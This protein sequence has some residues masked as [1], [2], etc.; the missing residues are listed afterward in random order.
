ALQSLG[1]DAVSM[2]VDFYTYLNKLYF[3][4]DYD[5]AFLGSTFEN[6]DVDWLAY[7]F[8]SEYSD[9]PYW[10]FPNFRNSSYDSWRNQLLHSADY[11]DVY[12]A[13]IE[14]Q[15]IL[16]YECPYI[17]A[18]ENLLLSAYRN[19]R[20]EGHV[21]DFA[22][23]AAGWW[24]NH[25]VHLKDALG[26]PYGG[27]FRWAIPL[28]RESFNLLNTQSAYEMSLKDE[29]YDR[30]LKRTPDGEIIPWLAE[31]YIAENHWDNPEVPEG[32]TRLTFEFVR[33]ASWSDGMP[34]TAQDAAF[35][36]N[37]YYEHGLVGGDFLQEDLYAAYAPTDYKLVVEFTGES[38]WYITS[39][40]ELSVLPKHQLAG[41][42]PYTWSPSWDEIITSG[43]FVLVERVPG[44]LIRMEKNPRYFR[45]PLNE[46]TGE[47][48][49]TA[50]L[51][52]NPPSTEPFQDGLS[53]ELEMHCPVGEKYDQ[54]L[55]DY[56]ETEELPDTV[57]KTAGG[58]TN[59]I[60]YVSS[61]QVADRLQ[62]SLDIKWKMDLGPAVVL[63][64]SIASARD[65][66]TLGDRRGVLF[67]KADVIEKRDNSMDGC[68]PREPN[69]L[70]IRDLI[71][72]TGTSASGYTGAGVTVGVVDSGTDF[73]HPDLQG[74]ISTDQYGRPTSYDPTGWGIQLM[75]RANSSILADPEAWL[76]EGNVLTYEQDGRYYLNI[77]GWDP[78][79]NNQGG[80]RHLM[81]LLPPYGDGYPEGD[82]F[83]FI[84]AY[85]Y[86][87]GIP[88]FSEFVFNEM[89]KDWEI[90][91]PS[92][93]DYRIGWVHEQRQDRYAKVFAP[94]LIIDGQQLVIDWNGS[95]AWTQMWNWA[96]HDRSIDLSSQADRDLISGKMDWSF[97]D[98]VAD[99]YIFTVDGNNVLS[100]DVD[101]DSNTDWGLGSLSWAYDDPGF[102]ADERLFCGIRSDAMAFALMYTSESSHGQLVS[103]ALGSRGIMQ[104]EIYENGS[105]YQL[106]G[107][108]TGAELMAVKGVTSGSDLGALAWSAGFHLNETT[109]YWEY[110]GQHK[111]DIVSNS[112][113]Y[114]QGSYLDLTFLTMTWDLVSAPGF[115][116]PDNPGTLFIFSA[117][118]SGSGYLTSSPPATSG[119]VVSVGSVWSTRSTEGDTAPGLNAYFSSNGPSLVGLAKPDIVAPGAGV[120]SG[121]F[122]N[123]LLGGESYKW[124]QGTSLSCPIASGAAAIILE[125]LSTNGLPT[126]SMTLKEILLS[127]AQDL[128]YDAF[129]QGHG[130]VDVENAVSAI[131][132]HSAHHYYF[133][134]KDSYNNY[135]DVMDDAWS[136]WMFVDWSGIHQTSSSHPRDIGTASLYFGHVYLGETVDVALDAFGYD[137]SQKGLSSFDSVEAWHYSGQGPFTYGIDTYSYDVGGTS[138][139]GFHNLTALIES[140]LYENLLGS[141]Y[142]T[143][144]LRTCPETSDFW[145]ELVDW[146]DS[147]ANGIMNGYINET[148]FGDR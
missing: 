145:V 59:V 115:A 17:I 122:Q 69:M 125:A 96:A 34:L 2:P 33:N 78:L 44:Q 40:G 80:T 76:A 134:S 118:N 31:S 37:Y 64:A 16:A 136:Q 27:S 4:H 54:V 148:D 142:S 85:E 57:V 140:S 35:A 86:Y 6:L 108:A 67:V 19:D 28:D 117:G 71:G 83:G 97:I 20:F 81:G 114:E 94:A 72:A 50:V 146:E 82:D 143:L 130:A 12:D 22:D 24:T 32:H 45:N 132:G 42:D 87:W 53:D 92:G 39:L 30:I 139:A 43:Q 110:T 100:A 138:Y 41:V 93:Q 106:P 9:E 91:A 101:G 18:Y 51:P 46:A 21:N 109:G 99:G 66:R 58:D 128:G 131:E 68:Y 48:S 107:I 113:N 8:W 137:G 5:I 84:G 124:W 73:S 14:M 105:T 89:W 104:H 47:E 11:Q 29:L 38:Y 1:I 23:G 3:H 56:L 103:S 120:T 74:A 55:L 147:D 70:E 112:W 75:V 62:E 90:P 7:D 141:P 77:T 60:V 123:I 88:Q 25:K 119:A 26:G 61:P 111:A 98:D 79:V 129:V 65:L 52:S 49:S 121:A 95:I 116:H 63:H 15:R 144:S 13:A 127:S 10:N 102:F 36:I 135:A 126:D 133:E